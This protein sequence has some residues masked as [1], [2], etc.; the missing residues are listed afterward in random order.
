MIAA[1][2][3]SVLSPAHNPQIYRSIVGNLFDVI[4]TPAF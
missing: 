2:L 3:F 4:D 1:C